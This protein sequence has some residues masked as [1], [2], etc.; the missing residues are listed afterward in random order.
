MVKKKKRGERG[1]N[2]LTE[3]DLVFLK[4]LSK[5]DYS[6]LKLNKKLGIAHMSTRRHI[7][8]LLKLGL[9]SRERIKKTN[10]SIIRIT[11]DGTEVLNLFNRLLKK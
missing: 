5:K 7:N 11:K 3:M 2:I 9:I 8:W 4:E 1:S 6:I 10:K